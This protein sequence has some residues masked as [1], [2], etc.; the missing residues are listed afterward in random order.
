MQYRE[1]FSING[2]NVEKVSTLKNSLLFWLFK[3]IQ[4]TSIKLITETSTQ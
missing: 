2:G 3:A 4:L 1:I